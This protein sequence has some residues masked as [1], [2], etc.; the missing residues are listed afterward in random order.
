[1]D[2]MFGCRKEDDDFRKDA[3]ETFSEIEEFENYS[4]SGLGEMT[5]L[6]LPLTALVVQ[7]TDFILTHISNKK[8]SGRVVIIKGK[9]YS[10]E[11]YS[12]DEVIEI[13]QEL[14]K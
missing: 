12:K 9:K 1:M 14:K 10:F 7:I 3:K 6:I 8:N 11:G 4:F 5:I 13:L 2:I